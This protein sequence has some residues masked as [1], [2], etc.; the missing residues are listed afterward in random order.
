MRYEERRGLLYVALAVFFFSTSPVFIVWADPMHPFLKTWGRML[1]AALA[2]GGLA[3]LTRDRARDE[4]MRA[5]VPERTQGNSTVRFLAYGLV[6]ALHFLFY[7]SSL[8]FT[9]AAHALSLVY[10]AP[11]FVALFSS[12][13]LKERLRRRQW[14]GIGITVLGVAILAGLE[15]QMDLRMAF[16]DLLALFSAIMFGLYSIAGRYERERYPLLVYA[17][18]VYWAATL[19]LVPFALFSLP[20][21]RMEAWDWTKIGAIVAVGVLSGALGH[22]LY[23]ASLRRV[24][25]AYVN[26]IASQEVTGGIILSWLFL[27]QVPSANSL[28]GALVTLVGIGLVLR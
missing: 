28:A 23:N 6:A 4:S 14:A 15:P 25:A 12:L 24:H 26:I 3:W 17:S 20:Q 21:M 19:W 2:V 10:T 8:G 1:V 5:G 9:T 16:G 13:F 22:T 7:I 27:S 18:R 11:I